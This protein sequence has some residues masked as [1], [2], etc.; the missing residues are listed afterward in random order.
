MGP[1]AME[2]TRAALHTLVDTLL[3]GDTA[4]RFQQAVAAIGGTVSVTVIWGSADRII[5]AA[6]AEYVAGAVRHLLD[7][8]GRMP[9][10]EQ[11]AHA[12]TAIEQTIARAG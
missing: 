10:M 7:G 6:Q 9:H 12:Q 1:G 5:P 3:D 11:P 2:L 4:H 8:T